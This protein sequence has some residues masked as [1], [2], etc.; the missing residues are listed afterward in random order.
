MNIY[1]KRNDFVIFFDAFF[2]QYRNEEKKE[3]GK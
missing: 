1:V 2:L 3:R